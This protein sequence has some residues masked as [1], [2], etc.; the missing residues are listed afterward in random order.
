MRQEDIQVFLLVVDG[1]S[2]STGMLPVAM[3]EIQ[4][5]AVFEGTLQPH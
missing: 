3:A 4:G 2:H 5:L 1:V